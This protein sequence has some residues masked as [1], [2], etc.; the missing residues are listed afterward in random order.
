MLWP[1]VI[2]GSSLASGAVP[3]TS[4]GTAFLDRRK[5]KST[6]C[7]TSSGLMVPWPAAARKGGG[8][9]GGA[10]EAELCSRPRFVQHSMGSAA[11]ARTA[12]PSARCMRLP[13]PTETLQSDPAAD[14]GGGRR[15]A[16]KQARAQ[17][18]TQMQPLQLAIRTL[19]V[20]LLR[21]PGLGH[22]AGRDVHHLHAMERSAVVKGSV[23]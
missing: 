7:A 21:K 15:A 5:Q 8:A 2:H 20:A 10:L 13:T 9:A 6:A 23:S 14:A 19:D 18:Q 1:K 16:G 17:A 22:V 11:C 4:S 3:P 12:A